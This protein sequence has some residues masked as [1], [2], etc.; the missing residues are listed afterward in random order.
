M[1]TFKDSAAEYRRT[2]GT[3]PDNS[4]APPSGS[5]EDMI[6]K[7]S[8]ATRSAASENAIKSHVL[9]AFSLSLI[10][11]PIFDFAMLT[12][13][14]VKMVHALGRIHGGQ[15][16]HDSRLEAIILSL[17]S[18]ALPVLG[19]Q[20]LS[21]ALKAMPGIGSLVGSGGV[22]V[23][24][25]LLTYAV[26]RVFVKHFESGGTYL[27]LDMKKAREQLKKEME[28]GREAVSNLRKRAPGMRYSAT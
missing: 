4:D 27:N 6:A 28:K 17:V 22:A 2:F 15:S 7:V 20:G 5:E 16:F 8:S 1:G 23:S 24:G 10:P 25:G 12:A 3:G 13:N 9:V 18:G 19:V 11:I 21:S 26:G 14:Q